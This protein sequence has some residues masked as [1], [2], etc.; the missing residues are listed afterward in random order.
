V[1][2]SVPVSVLRGRRRVVGR[3]GPEQGAQPT[4]RQTATAL[5]GV[6]L[7]VGFSKRDLGR[8]AAEADELRFDR[9]QVV[10]REGAP[11]ETL[12]VILSG[13]ARVVRGGRTL[14]RLRPGDFFGELST[15]DG[16]PR[17][18]TIVAGTP[19]AVIRLFRRTL[20][21]MVKREPQLALKL[22]DGIV[23]R[24]REIDR[25]LEA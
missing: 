2:Q 4:R 22:M 7:F 16:G 25:R 17:T 14:A 18:A 19:V 15:L 20:I 23:R 9:G 11:G 24:V 21:S 6:P 1:P 5:A 3:P 10:V 8:L 13:E 12:F